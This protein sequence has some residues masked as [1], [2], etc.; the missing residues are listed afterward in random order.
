MGHRPSKC[1]IRELYL[2]H[3]VVLVADFMVELMVGSSLAFSRLKLRASEEKEKEYEAVTLWYD[4][5]DSLDLDA[6]KGV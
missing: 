3:M 6:Y 1:S 4:L 2:E 5:K